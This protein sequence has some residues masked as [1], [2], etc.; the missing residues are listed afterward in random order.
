MLNLRAAGLSETESK[1]YEVLIKEPFWTP[2]KMAP[3][4][5]ESRTNVYKI[6]DK[7]VVLGLAKKYD[8]N[9]K[10]HYQATNPA[11]LL[12]L[13]REMRSQR[14]QD[15]K[16]LDLDV[17]NLLKTYTTTHEQPGI[18][19]YQGKN[20]IGAIFDQIASST[21]EVLFVHTTSGVDY[22]GFD[23]MHALRMRAVKNG[24]KR[25]ALTPDTP[26]ATVDYKKTDSRVLL[27]RT[28]LRQRDYEIPVEWGAFDETLYIIVYGQDAL[29]IT[30]QSE[31]IA[32]AFRQLFKIMESG[33][34]LQPW[35]QQLPV[36][37]NKQSVTQ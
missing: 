37:A 13:S 5:N 22:F 28:W 9:K 35:Y 21:E 16:Q 11:N 12:A 34:R 19:Y 3:I 18:K 8:K 30:I 24:V 2:S 29:G 6:L 10:I 36:R 17:Q 23:T 14:E 26:L 31:P 20:E 27:E 25:R 15:E 4:V 1:C 33:Q 32:K 7:L